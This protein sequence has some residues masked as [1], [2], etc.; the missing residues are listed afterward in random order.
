MPESTEGAKKIE[1]PD[2]LNEMKDYR[3]ITIEEG[4]IHYLAE[5]M[6]R[7]KE[8]GYIPP[9]GWDWGFWPRW[10]LDSTISH[11]LYK[12]MLLKTRSLDRKLVMGRPE[13]KGLSI[14][15]KTF[16]KENATILTD[17]VYNLIEDAGS[18]VVK[19]K[20]LKKAE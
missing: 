12:M 3:W 2:V 10:L 11:Y 1:K 14:E 9:F 19:R 18:F 17:K 13:H 15:E 16:I 5:F 8:S 7:L 20:N 4:R 6:S